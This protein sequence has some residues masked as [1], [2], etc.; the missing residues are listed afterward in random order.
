MEGI[1][2]TNDLFLHNAGTPR[3]LVEAFA[4]NSQ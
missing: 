3:S 1:K 2:G 4:K